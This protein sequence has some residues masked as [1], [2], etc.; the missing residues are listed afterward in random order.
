MTEQQ[1]DSLIKTI[2]IIGGTGK[3]GSALARRWALAGYRV[4]IGSRSTESAEQS[5]GEINSE[6]DGD[7]II[8]MSNEDAA[9]A[10][11][12]VV[13]S[14]PYSA[15]KAVI[16][17]LKPYLAG[18]T[19]IDLTV[20]LQPPA[21]RTVHVPDGHAAALE[22]QSYLGDTAHVVA[23]FQNISHV[24]LMDP[25]T[26]ID[27][28]VLVTGDDDAA[29]TDAMTLVKSAGMRAID[30]GPLKN[31]V[32]VEALTPVLLYINKQYGIKSSGIRITGIDAS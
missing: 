4:I 15:H 10:A 16:E 19:V 31:S 28:D 17:S 12:I 2:G 18:K 24:K 26:P 3:E 13:L 7:Y 1:S 20:P 22:A 6:L 21:V 9:K 23:A 8:G 11:G 30:A 27:C 32:A 14:V 5:A 25:D 29:K